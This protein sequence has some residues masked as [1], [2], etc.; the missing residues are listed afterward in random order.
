LPVSRGLLARVLHGSTG[1]IAAGGYPAAEVVRI[2]G[3]GRA[4]EVVQ[5]P[6]G[7]DPMRFR[8]LDGGARLAA[9]LRIGLPAPGP[10]VV[11]ASRLV[12]RKGVDVLIE[13][14]T[15]L[16]PHHPDLVVAVAG[17]GRDT[18]RL[19]RIAGR[20][21]VK[22]HFLGR[23]P[24]ADLPDLY[25]AAD[26]FAMLCR[27]RWGGL[28]QEGFGIVFMEAAACGV[29]QVAGDSGGAAEAVLDG[30]TGLVVR[31][32]RQPDAVAAAL[33]RILDDGDLRRRMG[34]AARTRATAEFDWDHLAGTL[35]EALRRWEQ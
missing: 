29:A 19:R 31:D 6:P 18:S 7:V 35:D 27:D 4:P 21:G 32:P 33:A 30:L 3:A 25:G 23:L 11:C 14:T 13:A 5:V 24:D 2:A 22:V 1:V 9:R 20:L 15:R 10:L 12:P 8:P 34:E 26:V 28:E 17:A 16:L